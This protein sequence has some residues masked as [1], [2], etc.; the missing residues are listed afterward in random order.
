MAL[1]LLPPPRVSLAASRIASSASRTSNFSR[2]FFTLPGSSPT[3][4]SLTATRRLPYA[5]APL[6]DL[7]SDIDSYVQFVPYCSRSRVTQWSDPDAAGR[8]WPTLADL[9]VGWGGFDEVF[10]S[11]LRCVPGVSVEAVSGSTQPGGGGPDA[12]AVFRSLV[13][14]WSVKEL[15]SLPS[16][17]TEVHLAIDFQFT[18]PLYA[19][20]S[21]AVSDKVAGLMIEAFEK[22]ARQKLGSRRKL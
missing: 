21:A 20:V 12:S 8:R 11:R 22:Q 17:S 14:R 3:T 10:T 9:H 6:Y 2:S 18:N 5:P 13:T 4:Q 16:P 15:A 1:R 19:A 7:I